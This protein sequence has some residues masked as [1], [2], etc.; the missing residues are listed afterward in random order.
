MAA[1]GPQ[2][3]VFS[4]QSTQELCAGYHQSKGKREAS[5]GVGGYV[6]LKRKAR[7]AA[8]GKWQRQDDSTGRQAARLCVGSQSAVCGAELPVL[9]AGP[10]RC[11]HQATVVCGLWCVVAWAVGTTQETRPRRGV[12]EAGKFGKEEL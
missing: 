7:Q 3:K 2:Q 5:C 8:S 10:A 4:T 11:T 1:E 9:H 6:S 12:P